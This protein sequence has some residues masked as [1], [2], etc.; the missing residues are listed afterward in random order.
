MRWIESLP[1]GALGCSVFPQI[2]RDDEGFFDTGNELIDRVFVSVTA[3]K[4]MA[5]TIGWVPPGK[6]EEQSDEIHRLELQVQSLQDELNE[7]DG[8][9][10]AVDVMESHGYRARKKPGRPSTKAA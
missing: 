2:G 1:F 7:L 3:V 8:F 9:R 6:L 5:R 4:E 10:S